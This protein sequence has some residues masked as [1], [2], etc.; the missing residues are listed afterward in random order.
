MNR[1]RGDDS[2]SFRGNHW[3]EPPRGCLSPE[4]GAFG[5]LER[6]SSPVSLMLV[7]VMWSLPPGADEHTQPRA[8]CRSW[9]GLGELLHHTERDPGLRIDPR[10]RRDILVA[11]LPVG[12]QDLESVGTAQV[13]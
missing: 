5:G 2:V 11:D 1:Y 10:A 4:A 7:I 12:I 6:G 8:S 13:V 3:R 9:A